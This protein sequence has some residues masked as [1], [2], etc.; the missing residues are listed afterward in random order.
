MAQNL[1]FDFNVEAPV[2][3]LFI[4]GRTLG[5]MLLLAASA[6]SGADAW[7]AV[8][9]RRAPRPAAPAS[10]TE[11]L[12]KTPPNPALAAQLT[13]KKQPS[14]W[15][16]IKEN[17]GVNYNSFFA[18]PGPGH[19]WNVPPGYTGNPSDTGL[20]FFNLVSAKWKFS[21]RLALDIQFRNQLVVTNNFEFRHQGQRFGVS[22]KLLSGDTW[23]LGGAVNSDLPLRPLMGQI[24]SDRTLILNPGMFTT[25][26]WQPK[27]SK[28][29]VFALLTPRVWF[30][31]DRN[32]VARQDIQG[33][34]G[35][36]GLVCD[37]RTLKPEAILSMNPSI[38]YQ[39]TEKVG[40]R[41]GTTL[42]LIKTAGNSGMQRDFMPF[43]LGVVYDLDPRL[44]IYTYVMT[45]SVLDDSVR[46]DL[47]GI[48]QQV[49][50]TKTASLNLWLSGT[51]F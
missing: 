6:L 5:A 23:T 12:T 24:A 40:T 22:G 9:A 50:W 48:A 49:S 16:F 30:Y 38:N 20:N 26:D 47:Y 37:P 25:F 29:S 39:L 10:A 17:F 32:A 46:R 45:S 51:L 41:F 4:Q 14:T 15:E 18:G 7:A 34:T 1:G 3:P 31:R 36:S 11:N 2:R 19:D 44:S 27:G 13:E 43:E 28:W 21:K 8:K 33:C 42:Q 35:D